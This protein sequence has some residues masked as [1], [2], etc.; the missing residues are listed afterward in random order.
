MATASRSNFHTVHIYRAGDSQTV[1]PGLCATL[2]MTNTIFYY[3]VSITFVND[4]SFSLHYEDGQLVPRNNQLVHRGKYYYSSIGDQTINDEPWL[5][6]TRS[7]GPGGPRTPSFKHA[8]RQRDGRYVLTG[9]IATTGYAGLWCG[10]QAAHLFPISHA[11]EWAQEGY[12]SW[13]S[14]E[15]IPQSGGTINSVQNGML[16]QNTYH[17]LFDNYLIAINPDVSIQILV[18]IAYPLILSLGQL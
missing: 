7:I 13:I 6:R 15:Y 17:E 3:M 12:G 18:Y 11:T 4:H 8:I 5:V 16:I 14:P 2:D 9:E 1:L 10:F